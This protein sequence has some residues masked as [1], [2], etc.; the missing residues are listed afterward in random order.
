MMY[1]M[2]QYIPQG[3]QCPVCKRVHSPSVPSCDCCRAVTI[4][5]TSVGTAMNK[6]GKSLFDE[7][8]DVYRRAMTDNSEK[9]TST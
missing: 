9:E 8:V 7:Y 5:G 6:D 1:D 2:P 3:W 4:T